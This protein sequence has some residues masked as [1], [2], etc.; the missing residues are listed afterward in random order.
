MKYKTKYNTRKRKGQKGGGV[1]DGIKGSLQIG[2]T[3]IKYIKKCNP[4]KL[5]CDKDEK[6][7]ALCVNSEE[8]CKDVNYDYEYIPSNP[9]DPNGLIEVIGTERNPKNVEKFIRFFF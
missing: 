3:E 8:D 4:G 5:M 7:Y 9:K 2:D 1:T 6:N